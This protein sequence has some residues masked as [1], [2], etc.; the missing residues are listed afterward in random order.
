MGTGVDLLMSEVDL[1]SGVVQP[2][3]GLTEVVVHDL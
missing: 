3:L 2:V 1:L